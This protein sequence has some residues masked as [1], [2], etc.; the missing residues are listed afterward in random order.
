M[1]EN[2]AALSIADDDSQPSD[3]LKA[4][5]HL[6]LVFDRPAKVVHTVE[7]LRDKK[8]VYGI[9]IAKDADVHDAGM[10]QILIRPDR[11]E[12][13]A[14]GS[15]IYQMITGGFRHGMFANT[16]EEMLRREI[17]FSMFRRAGLLWPPDRIPSGQQCN[18]WSTDKDEQIRNR[19]KYHGLRLACP[20]TTADFC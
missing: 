18:Y 2:S 17:H 11:L 13:E 4:P 14:Y 10:K 8:G 12:Y 1:S 20:R 15:P 3:Y 16:S 5:G 7:L 19:Q 9:G 6:R